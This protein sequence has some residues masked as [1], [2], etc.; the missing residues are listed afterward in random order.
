MS[1]G[2]YPASRTMYGQV[3]A[4]AVDPEH[5]AFTLRCECRIAPCRPSDS[6]CEV[7]CERSY[8]SSFTVDHVAN[9]VRVFEYRTLKG[10]SSR[11]GFAY[12]DET[13]FVREISYRLCTA[14]CAY[15]KPY[16]Y[17]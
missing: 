6:G 17:C 10:D 13:K 2:E 16:G 14:T 9:R 1:Y 8:P 5:V 15:P 4:V 11:E 12:V 3:A 7:E